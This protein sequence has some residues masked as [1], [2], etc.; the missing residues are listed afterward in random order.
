[1]ED[2]LSATAIVWHRVDLRTERQPRY[3]ITEVL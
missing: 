2:G 3:I 1:M